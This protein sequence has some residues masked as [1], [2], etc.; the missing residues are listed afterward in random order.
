MHF[1]FDES[2]DFSLPRSDEHRYGVI[3]ALAVPDPVAPE[4]EK[5]Y[6]DFA[7]TLEANE[8]VNGEPKGARF[9]YEHRKKFGDMLGRF[10]YRIVFTPLTFDLSSLTGDRAEPKNKMV[11]ALLDWVPKMKHEAPRERIALMAKQM[12]NL[13]TPQIHRLY[14]LAAAFREVLAASI[15]FL[16]SGENE[17]SWEHLRFEVDRVQKQ[18]NGREEQLFSGL[19]GA[20]LYAWSEKLPVQMITEVHT[21]DLLI[22]KK[23]GDEG[24]LNLAPMLIDNIHWKNSADSWGIQVADIAAT[25]VADAVREP[26]SY[27]AVKPFIKLMRACP[28]PFGC[29]AQSLRR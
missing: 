19:I 18:A 28:F 5:R 16:A 7:S 23:Y 17:S 14:S 20:W 25:I 22:F 8:R 27:R 24:G 2:G 11:Q 4:L 26:T 15:T 1:F 10:I 21:D 12:A 9:C 3:A 6:R 13:S 29:Q